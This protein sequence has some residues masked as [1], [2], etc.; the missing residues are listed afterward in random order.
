MTELAVTPHRAFS[1]AR[2]RAI[3]SNTLLELVRLKVFY[4]LLVFAL[5]I[6][7]SSAFT[8]RLSFQEQFQV[9]KDVSLG[10]MSIFSWLLAVLATAMLLPKDI[11]DRTLY[12][13]LAKPVPRFEYLLG[14]LLGV[15]TLLFVA[16]SLMSAVFVVVLYVREQSAIAQALADNP[17]D[18]AAAAVEA[19]RATTF[20]KSLLPCIVVIYLKAA[21]CGTFTLFLST[22]A[23]SWIFTIIVSVVIYLIGHVQ[24]I[25]REYWLASA[26]VG[27]PTKIFLAFVALLFPDLTAFNL[28]DDVVAGNAVAMGLFLQTAALG[29]TYITAY[30]LAGYFMFSSK[31]L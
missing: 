15:L 5:L 30:F 3:A 21:L 1:P 24:P 13:I 6:I 20:T 23:T 12:T 17:A 25:A 11:E 14:K 10:A 28:V 18:Q 26:A 19:V 2:I 4:F 22:F 29:V 7:G 31:E 16:L 27:A 8:A 9:L